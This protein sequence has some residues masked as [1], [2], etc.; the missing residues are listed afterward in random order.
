MKPVDAHCHL[1]FDQYDSDRPEVMERAR[2]EL[3]FVVNA[4]ASL[5]NNRRTLELADRHPGFVVPALGLHPTYTDEFSCLDEVKEQIETEEPAA[6]G[7][8]GMDY[9][10]VTDREMREKQ[11]EVFREMLSLAGDLGKPAVVHSRDAEK[12]AV[13]ILSSHGGKVMLHAFNGRPELAKEAV[14]SGMKIGVTC[15]VLYSNRVQELVREL[16]VADLMLETDSPFLY[17]GD[18]NE[19]SNVKESARKIAELK[20]LPVEDVVEETTSNAREFFGR[21]SQD[22]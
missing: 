21:P 17:Q 22:S 5:E 12:Q 11:E 2:E 16:R 9:H 14:E 7:E 8:I 6:V 19:P 3:E 15:Q 4:G 20:D 18:R 13:R 10:H 1:D